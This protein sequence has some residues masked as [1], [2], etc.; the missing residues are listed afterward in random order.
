M[1]KSN[2]CSY[3]FEDGDKCD[4]PCFGCNDYC[5]EH[6]NEV[7]LDEEVPEE[8]GAPSLALSAIPAN[9]TS[10]TQ[11]RDV[12]GIMIPQLIWNNV[13]PKVMTALTSACLAQAKI[14]ELTDLTD[15]L[16]RLEALTESDPRYTYTLK[17]ED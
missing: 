15:Q 9:I 13:D 8:V 4:K 17:N 14:I 2:D 7:I 16:R 11:V 3:V 12:M 5:L 1:S 6:Y 10:I